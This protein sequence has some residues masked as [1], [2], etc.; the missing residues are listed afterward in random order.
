MD[1][2]VNQS[3]VSGLETGVDTS[4]TQ[5]NETVA[6]SSEGDDLDQ[7]LNKAF[8]EA[9]EESEEEAE[10]QKAE[11]EAEA[12]EEADEDSHKSR[13]EERKEQLQREIRDS[14]AELN[15]LKAEISQ[16][17]ELQLPSVE[18]LANY[19]MSQDEDIS[20]ADAAIE[21]RMRL[22]EAQNS[23]KAEIETIAE[24]RHEQILAT[25]NA[26][27]A[28]PELFDSSNPSFNP[29]LANGILEMYE[30]VAHVQRADDGEVISAT[31]RLQ[32]FLESIGEIYRLGVMRGERSGKA[33]KSRTNSK[34][35]NMSYNPAPRNNNAIKGEMTEDEFV[36]S[37]LE[38]EQKG[39]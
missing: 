23:R 35:V 28:Y 25:E 21:A 18:E 20:E 10:E 39:K 29:D 27:L 16:Y 6:N 22:V 32:P 17:Q 8:S 2:D 38:I 7:I 37:V 12:S 13:G 5:N 15:R 3:T 30:E 11:N 14:T 1:D 9:A 24:T 31:V 19:I 33:R 36:S 4:T 34:K 26:K